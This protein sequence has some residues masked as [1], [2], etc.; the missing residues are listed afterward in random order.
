MKQDND[1]SALLEGFQ[2]CG[3]RFRICAGRLQYLDKER[4]LLP[5]DH[6]LMK[7]NTEGLKQALIEQQRLH[8]ARHFLALDRLESEKREFLSQY[9]VQ[10]KA[11]MTTIREAA[12]HFAAVS[13]P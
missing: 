7:A 3:V 11:L 9:R 8:I 2:Q 6:A 4:R 1:Y 12:C 13:S 10:K 5:E